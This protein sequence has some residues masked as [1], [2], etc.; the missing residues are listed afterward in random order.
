MLETI[1]EDAIQMEDELIGDQDALE[2]RSS[3]QGFG[4]RDLRLPYRSL[5]R[6]A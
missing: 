6:S 5:C 2:M 1:S 3:S 4:D